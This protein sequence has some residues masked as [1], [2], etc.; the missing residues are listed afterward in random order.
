MDGRGLRRSTPEVRPPGTLLARPN[1]VTPVIAVSETASWPTNDRGLDFS[2]LFNQ[3]TAN[4]ILIGDFRV[5]ADPH[6]I[7]NNATEIFGEV[8]VDVGRD[9]AQR[10]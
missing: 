2:E 6:P 8:S 7:V 10:L 1:A 9:R 3:G 5:F 4:A